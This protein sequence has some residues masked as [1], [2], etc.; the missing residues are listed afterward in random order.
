MSLQGICAN[1]VLETSETQGTGNYAL[2]GPV[3]PY[4]SFAAAIGD[5]QLVLYVA[6]QLIRNGDGEV[7][8]Q[9]FE[10]GVGRL[11][12]GAP[13]ELERVE[14]FESSNG[15]AAVDWGPGTKTLYSAALAQ[16]L[17]LMAG[18]L[19][20]ARDGRPLV[21]A[22]GSRHFETGNVALGQQ[23]A[24]TLTIA[25]DAITPTRA[26]HQ[27]DT[28]AAA[29]S[30][31]LVT[32]A[33]TNI[34]D[35]GLLLLSAVNAGRSIVVKH[36]DAPTAGQIFLQTGRDFTLLGIRRAL[37]L[38][39]R[40][41]HWVE[42]TRGRNVNEIA[43]A[44][45]LT[46]ELTP[47]QLTGNADNYNPTGLAGASVL[48]MSTNA[49]RN[50][51]GIQG[52]A[53]GRIMLLG[54]VGSNNLVLVH[55]ATSTAANRFSLPGAANLTLLPGEW[56]MLRYDSTLSRWTVASAT[57][58]AR[59]A[60]ESNAGALALATQAEAEAGTNDA[61]AVTP[62][63]LRQALRATGS[64]PVYA[65]RAWVNFDGTLAS[66]NIRAQG[67]V[68]SVTRH[69]TGDFSVNFATA[70]PTADYAVVAMSGGL[71]TDDSAT[72]K[73][74]SA[75]RFT[76]RNLAGTL[77]NWANNSVVVFC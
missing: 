50:L 76:T 62:L 40:G 77:V 10:R 16:S 47:A 42:I 29:S 48:R 2:E 28:E 51:T 23:A 12:H 38:Q 17:P 35:G 1:G 56:T 71:C 61:K 30:D 9:I 4:G 45:L 5:G 37:L 55:D 69:A 15:G 75:Y 14:V 73:T 27:L 46:G 6:Q 21:V 53:A 25:S 31:D 64:A 11:H 49:S 65:A 20:A 63:K 54:N 52:G 18:E 57:A 36:Q 33:T 3:V 22:A 67:N 7:T 59:A 13:D 58:P 60:S 43:D 32:I 70:L 26:W 44:F 74:T 66:G 72:A 24:T 34:A 41:N 39:R 8:G 68:S 19:P